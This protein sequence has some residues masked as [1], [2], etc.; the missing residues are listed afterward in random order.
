[1]L[2][3][4]KWGGLVDPYN[5]RLVLLASDSRVVV[6]RHLSRTITRKEAVEQLRQFAAEGGQPLPANAR[7]EHTG[8]DIPEK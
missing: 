6:D 1:M 5:R 2:Y 4:V 3:E 7:F 8:V